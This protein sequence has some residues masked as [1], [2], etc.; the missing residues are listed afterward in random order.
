MEIDVHDPKY[1]FDERVRN[2]VAKGRTQQ[3]AEVIVTTVIT[4]K[5]Q[6]EPKQ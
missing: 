2:L 6:E 1:R 4:T 5:E 3:E